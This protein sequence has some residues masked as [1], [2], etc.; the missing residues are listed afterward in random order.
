[1]MTKTFVPSL[2]KSF[3]GEGDKVALPPSVKRRRD[4]WGQ[5]FFIVSC[6]IR[7]WKIKRWR[8]GQPRTSKYFELKTCGLREGN[9]SEDR[10]TLI[11]LDGLLLNPISLCLCL[12]LP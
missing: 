4:V 3:H 5:K 8:R 12:I 6:W 9:L 7:C 11:L 1:M 10:V 2:E